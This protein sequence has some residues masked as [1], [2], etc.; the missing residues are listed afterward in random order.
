ME[1][2]HTFTGSTQD[3]IWQKVAYDMASQKELLSYS[4]LVQLNDTQIYF[5]TDLDLGGGFEG[6]ISSTNFMAPVPENVSLR[7]SLH[8]Q[9]WMDEVGKFFGMEDVELG[10]PDIDEAFIIKTNQPDTLKQLLSDPTVHQLLLKHKSCELKLHDDA[11]DSGHETVLTFSKDEAILNIA[12]L[13]EIYD[14][15]YRLLQ[16]LRQ[17][18]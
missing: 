16:Q 17:L 5:D 9:G 10:Y 4:A 11:D 15:L 8:E 1:T 3:E 18:V 14:M 7:F 2:L 6:G 12:E 13:R